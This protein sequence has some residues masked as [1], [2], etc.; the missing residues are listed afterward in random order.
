MANAHKSAIDIIKS[1]TEYDREK[2]KDA[3][4]SGFECCGGFARAFGIPADELHAELKE[5]L[6]A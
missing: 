3:L 6:L 5:I 1:M 2:M 4:R